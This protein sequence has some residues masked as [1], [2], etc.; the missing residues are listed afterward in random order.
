MTKR[1]IGIDVM[2]GIAMVLV[3]LGHHRFDFMPE[4]YMRMFYWI[5]LLST[6]KLNLIFY[7][8]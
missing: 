6:K 5:S 1:L 4:W 8:I 7:D 2:Q 3:V